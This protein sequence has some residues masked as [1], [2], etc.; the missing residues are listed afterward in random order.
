MAFQSWIGKIDDRVNKFAAWKW[1]YFVLVPGI[2]LLVSILYYAFCFRPL[3]YYEVYEGQASYLQDYCG[4]GSLGQGIAFL[5]LVVLAIAFAIVYMVG[6]KKTGRLTGHKW[7]VFFV[8]LLSIF[9]TVIVFALKVN[10]QIG[11]VDWCL[12]NFYDSTNTDYRPGHWGVILDIFRNGTI[13]NFPKDAAGNYWYD[14]QYYQNKFWHYLLAYFMRF[15]GLFIHAGDAITADAA[16]HNFVFTETEDVLFESTRIMV[17]SI[18]IWTSLM[19]LK[20]LEKL[21]AHQER[22]AIAM[23]LFAFTPFFMMLP[24]IYNNDSLSFLFTLL[25][26]YW[27]IDWHEQFS[28]HAI[29]LIALNLGLGMATKFNA[30]VMALPIAALFVYELVRLYQ[31]KEAGFAG[32]F[33]EHPYRT[34]WLQIVAFAAIVFPL[35]LFFA[36]YQYKVYNIPFGYVWDNGVEAHNYIS[37]YY[38]VFIRFCIFPSPDMFFSIFSLPYRLGVKGSYYDHWGTEDFNIWTGFFKSAIFNQANM[39]SYP[40]VETV[41]FMIGAYF[42]Y[43]VFFLL[44]IYTLVYVFWYAIAFIGGH[45]RG[46]FTTRRAFLWAI[47]LTEI[48]SY[49]YFNYKYPY[50]CTAHCRYILEFFFPLYL[51]L[52]SGL[53]KGK[54]YLT[55][56]HQKHQQKAT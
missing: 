24:S 32:A 48:V 54:V 7:G 3:S 52:A 44:A 34:F 15:N 19:I 50:T 37:P 28:W 51:A 21:G 17:A 18:G 2:F 56:F 4:F 31:K 38:N 12:W 30:G 1:R 27:A 46:L 9:S 45:H 10:A 6:L 5:V 11:H 20:L 36:I 22:E 53:R 29:I 49:V 25:A 55:F 39:D 47:T 33:K 40:E 42:I 23:G 13:E 35:G 26:L 41:P 14:N 43:I 8:F 16:A